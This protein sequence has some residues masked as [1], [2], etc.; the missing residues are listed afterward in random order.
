MSDVAGRLAQGEQAVGHLA[1]YS[2]ACAA[3]GSTDPGLAGRLH[4]AYAREA[5]L[6]L[7]ALDADHAALAAAVET[8]Q[9]ALTVQDGQLLA[10]REAWDGAAADATLEILHRHSDASAQAIAAL[11][12]AAESMARL[13]ETLWGIVD[14]KV[15]ATQSLD[16]RTDGVRG[17]WL[18]AAQA[19]TTGTGDRSAASELVDQHVTPFVARDVAADLVA[20]LED[21]SDAIRRSFDCAIATVHDEPVGTFPSG[22]G[23]WSPGAGG[24]GVGGAAPWTAAGASPAPPV[25][26]PPAP[27]APSGALTDPA[28]ATAAMPPPAT[29]MSMPGSSGL[30]DIGSGMSGLSGL[31]QQ[32]GE[33]LGGLLP[34]GEGLDEDPELEDPDLENPLPDIEEAEED[35]DAEEDAD[36]EEEDKDEDTEDE[37]EAGQADPAQQPDAAS[38]EPPAEPL[39]AEAAA[40]PADGPAPTPAPSAPVADVVPPAPAPPATPCEIAADELPQAGGPTAAVR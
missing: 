5:G 2:A 39:P 19:L 18:S 10:L 13:R 12:A 9:E 38:G 3:L 30:P 15:D 6:D 27:P 28:A 24:P 40:P 34:A 7:G 31:G 1:S 8:A 36:K 35:E 20:A 25:A 17:D 4:E 22:G 16:A 26:P 32:F 37:E 23:A 29:P 11:G 14:A 21:A 33:L